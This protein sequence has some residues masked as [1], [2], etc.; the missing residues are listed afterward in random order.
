MLS[1]SEKALLAKLELPYSAVAIKTC[2]EKPDVPHYD[3]EKCA[4]CQFV[5]YVQDTGKT[6]YIESE[7][8]ACYGKLAMGMVDKQPV[9]AS[10]QAGY[11]F[12][13]YQTPM[14][15][16]QLYQKMPILEPH[17][18]KYVIFAPACDCMFDPD[19]LF[20]VADLPQADII[21]RATSWVSGDLWESCSS[22]V[23]SCAWMYAYPIIS[24][25]VNHI[26]TGF[27]HGL[28]RR[29]AYPA[30]LRM[31]SIPYRKIPEFFYA[32]AHMDWTLIA[33][34]EDEESKQDLA[35]R[36]AHWQ[37]MA[38]ESGSEVDLR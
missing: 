30:G 15:C 1:E 16:R 36:M 8:D 7:D 23:V 14:G 11:D 18:I 37:E 9:T 13:C 28:K 19:L 6:F 33:F 27:Y 12:G 25:K 5:K 26:T 2:F 32:L 22:P 29:K 38:A 34:R 4:F 17:T 10:G 20:F 3:G 35:R 21:M 24:G 31:I